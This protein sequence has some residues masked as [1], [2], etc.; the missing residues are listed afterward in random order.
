MPEEKRITLLVDAELHERLNNLVPHGFRKHL[1]GALIK[2]VLD[3]VETDGN[4]VIGAVMDG[5]FK[6][7]RSDA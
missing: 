2:L 3:A 4:I 5:Q 6:L 1:V 7:V